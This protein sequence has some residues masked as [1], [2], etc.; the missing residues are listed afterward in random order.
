MEFSRT[1]GV[2]FVVVGSILL[3]FGYQST[4]TVT[5]QVYETFA[6]RYTQATMLY[7]IGGAASLIAGLLL[8]LR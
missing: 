8:M 1:A 6:G 2:V 4:E 3:Y 5:E 7:L